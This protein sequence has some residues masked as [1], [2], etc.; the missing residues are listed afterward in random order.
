MSSLVSLFKL[1]KLV[2]QQTC[3]LKLAE[4]KNYH[5]QLQ[6]RYGC[7]HNFFLSKYPIDCQ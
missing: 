5:R 3:T 1:D 2:L 6:L 7:A 4:K